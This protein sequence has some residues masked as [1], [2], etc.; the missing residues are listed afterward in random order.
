M[1]EN[2]MPNNTVQ[3]SNPNDQP[4]RVVANGKLVEFPAHAT[5]EVDLEVFPAVFVV[6]CESPTCRKRGAFC[7]RAHAGAQLGGG[8]PLLTYVARG[9]E[10]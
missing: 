6:Q 9:D 2:R 1:K 8:A 3:I 7:R 5:V 4:M 10:E